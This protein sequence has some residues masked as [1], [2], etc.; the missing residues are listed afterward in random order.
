M[1]APPFVMAGGHCGFGLGAAP[2]AVANMEALVEPFV[3]APR[4]F[5]VVPMLGAFLIDFTNALVI[6]AYINLV[7]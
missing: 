6:T 2:N 1:C 4:A 7:R 3:A 5:L